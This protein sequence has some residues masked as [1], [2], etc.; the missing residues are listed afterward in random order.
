[1]K[2]NTVEANMPAALLPA[3]Q[4][5]VPLFMAQMIGWDDVQL[6]HAATVC[7]EIVAAEGDN[8][9]F[10]SVRKGD[11]ARAFNALAQG[12]AVLAFAP[13]GVDFAGEHWQAGELMEAAPTV[14]LRRTLRDIE[15]REDLV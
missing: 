12:L 7:G 6:A 15:V 11:S 2:E 4:M 1:M 5:S 9:L 10:K 3:L 13:G 14:P 8:I